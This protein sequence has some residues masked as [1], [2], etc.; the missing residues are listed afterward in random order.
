M[1]IAVVSHTVRR[2][3]PSPSNQDVQG[4]AC[5]GQTEQNKGDDE[6]FQEHLNKAGFLLSD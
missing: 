3:P 2:E 4:H 5:H 6:D 1:H